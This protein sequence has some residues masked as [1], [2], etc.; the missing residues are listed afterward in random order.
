MNDASFPGRAVRLLY[1]AVL[2]ANQLGAR[3]GTNSFGARAPRGHDLIQRVLVINLDRQRDRWRALQS[4][5]QRIADR[6]GRPLAVITTRFPGVD[7]RL[8]SA[9]RA[10]KEVDRVYSLAEQ[11]FVDSNPALLDEETAGFDHR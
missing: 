5:L 4:E 7:A 2:K 1:R 11:L 6:H 3:T 9:R 8:N 10:N